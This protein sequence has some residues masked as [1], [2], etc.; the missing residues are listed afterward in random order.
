MDNKETKRNAPLVCLPIM[1]IIINFLQFLKWV[2]IMKFDYACSNLI[3]YVRICVIF[4]SL[5]F[6]SLIHQL[7]PFWIWKIKK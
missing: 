2:I 4:I 7:L 3:A 1:A 6:S 5:P